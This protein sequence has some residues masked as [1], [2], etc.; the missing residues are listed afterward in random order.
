[1]PQIYEKYLEMPNH[2]NLNPRKE[3]NFSTYVDY[4]LKYYIRPSNTD[5][6]Y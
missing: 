4:H 3:V 6:E 1:M 2:L 5:T